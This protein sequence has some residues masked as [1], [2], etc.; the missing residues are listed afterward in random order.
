[1]RLRKVKTS[2][3]GLALAGGM[4]LAGDSAPGGQGPACDPVSGDGATAVGEVPGVF[5]GSAGL[6]IRGDE[7]EVSVNTILCGLPREGDNGTMHA[8]TSHT[9]TFTDG[10]SFTT[11]DKATMEP[12]EGE[13]GA[14]TLNS[15]MR[16]CSTPCGV[17]EDC[18]N[19]RGRLHAHGEI[20]LFDEVNLVEFPFFGEASFDI[21]GVVCLDDE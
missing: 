6:R 13:P 7:F 1:M 21:H 18:E 16:V 17:K 2:V 20:D 4:F 19:A 12:I 11:T 14:F 10:S 9:F 5:E 15:T 3:L 8:T